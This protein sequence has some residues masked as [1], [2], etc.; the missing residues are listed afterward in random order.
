MQNIEF[1]KKEKPANLETLVTRA[2]GK[3]SGKTRAGER[4][5]VG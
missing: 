5:S 1:A 2:W 4:F 3:T